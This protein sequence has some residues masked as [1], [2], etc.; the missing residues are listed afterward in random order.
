MLKPKN[1]EIRQSK[2]RNMWVD[3]LKHKLSCQRTYYK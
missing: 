2:F 3:I 1:T